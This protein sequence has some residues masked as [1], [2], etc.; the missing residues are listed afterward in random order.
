MFYF[1]NETGE[2]YEGLILFDNLKDN[3]L[4]HVVFADQNVA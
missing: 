1:L 3:D 2:T 4:H